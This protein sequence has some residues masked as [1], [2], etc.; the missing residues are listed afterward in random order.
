M[1]IGSQTKPNAEGH[2]W[3]NGI[4]ND[5]IGHFL[6]HLSLHFKAKLSAQSLL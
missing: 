2:E 6:V 1:I 5:G 4:K 3:K